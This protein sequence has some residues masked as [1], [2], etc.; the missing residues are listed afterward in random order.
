MSAPET[1]WYRDQGFSVEELAAGSPIVEV[2]CT[3]QIES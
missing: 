1:R 2:F 3:Q